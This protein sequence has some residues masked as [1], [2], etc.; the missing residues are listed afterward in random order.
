MLSDESEKMNKGRSLN[1]IFTGV[2]FSL[3]KRCSTVQTTFIMVQ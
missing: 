3:Q 2:F 1:V